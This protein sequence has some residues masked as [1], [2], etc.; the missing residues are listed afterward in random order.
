MRSTYVPYRLEDRLIS[1]VVELGAITAISIETEEGG[2][3]RAGEG[4]S[5]A[6]N[7]FN[8]IERRIHT[9]LM[10]KLFCCTIDT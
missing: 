7:H 3:G 4:F 8:D 6:K 2:E 1:P 10:H 9:F 5:P